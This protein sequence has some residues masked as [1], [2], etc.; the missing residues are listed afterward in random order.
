M[1]ASLTTREP[2]GEVAVLG[3]VGDRVPHAGD[4]LFVHEVDDQLHLVQALEVRH[5]RGVARLGERLEPGAHERGEAAAQHGLLAEQ[6]GLGL[7]GE[8]GLDDPGAGAADRIGVRHRDVTG[9]AGRILRHGDERR[10]ATALG[11]GAAHEV[12][13][14]PSERS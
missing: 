5:L 10:H 13:R 9:L 4:A 12:A 6:V 7:L 3:G 2:A 1:V 11:V 14:D 8:R